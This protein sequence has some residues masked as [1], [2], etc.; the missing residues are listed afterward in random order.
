VA[1][2]AFVRCFH[3]PKT[4]S[5]H[6]T[7]PLLDLPIEELR[8]VSIEERSRITGLLA[9]NLFHRKLGAKTGGI[10]MRYASRDLTLV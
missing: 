8:L 3:T 4:Q 1:F 7:P 10:A 6:I 9:L 5:R 2:R